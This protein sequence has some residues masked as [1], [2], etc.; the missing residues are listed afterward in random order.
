M[1]AL[2]DC[3]VHLNSFNG[4][5][6]RLQLDGSFATV[7]TEFVFAFSLTANFGLVDAS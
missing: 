7:E 3:G 6:T 5:G 4:G 2:F 1:C